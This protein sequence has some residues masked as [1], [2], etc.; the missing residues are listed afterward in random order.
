VRAA[1]RG[2]NLGTITAM[3]MRLLARYG[4]GELEAAIGE[5]L[6]RNASH[7]NAVRLM[8]ERRR[9]QRQQRPPVAINLPEHVKAKDTP[10]HPHSLA[11]YDQL[12]EQADEE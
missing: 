6:T 9:E 1:E 2:D 8:L 10:V 3:L 7:P 5:A 11:T 4:G 12:K